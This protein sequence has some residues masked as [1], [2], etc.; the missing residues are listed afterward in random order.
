[1]TTDI[2]KINDIVWKNMVSSIHSLGEI[3]LNP[4]SFYR[5]TRTNK[6]GYAD[7]T[8][9]LIHGLEVENVSID[10]L[11]LDGKELLN[12][13]YNAINTSKYDDAKILIN[14]TSLLRIVRY[15]SPASKIS[16]FP[17]GAIPILKDFLT[18]EFK[19]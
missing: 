9:L 7:S 13:F 4:E 1:M 19:K 6:L 12:F 2:E 18:K 5:D 16:M 11:L 10:P 3:I 17:D 14:S 15:T 8:I